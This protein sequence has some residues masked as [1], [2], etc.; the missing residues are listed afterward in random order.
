M[1]TGSVAQRKPC[2]AFC[3]FVFM[4]VDGL[5][6]YVDSKSTHK[7]LLWPCFLIAT[8]SFVP[9]VMFL[10]FCDFACKGF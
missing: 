9:P 5:I 2:V 3:V 4:L 7:R 10:I 8:F 1:C 6:A